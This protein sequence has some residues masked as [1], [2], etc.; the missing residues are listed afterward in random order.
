MVNPQVAGDFLNSKLLEL[1]YINCI[2]NKTQK[3]LLK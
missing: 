3:F 2:W 1:H